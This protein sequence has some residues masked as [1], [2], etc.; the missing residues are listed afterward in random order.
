MS[1]HSDPG[2]LDAQPR[3]VRGGSR[4]GRN[5]RVQ[6]RLD[7]VDRGGERM[8]GELL[9]VVGV[10]CS[11]PG[12]AGELAFSLIDQVSV[13]LSGIAGGSAEAGGARTVSPTHTAAKAIPMLI[14]CDI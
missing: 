10:V 8:P 7:G 3:D 11:M 13:A 14:Q 2:A 6:R 4:A 1:T 5:R 9:V 12:V